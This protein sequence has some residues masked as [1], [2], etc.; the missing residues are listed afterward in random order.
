MLFPT[1]GTPVKKTLELM[2]RLNLTLIYPEQFLIAD[3]E[4]VLDTVS[5]GK[6]LSFKPKYKDKDMIL[7]AYKDYLKASN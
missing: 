5:L 2:D 1:W 4:Y 7:E 3:R 6:D